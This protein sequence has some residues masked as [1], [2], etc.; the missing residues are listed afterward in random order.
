M[1][2]IQKTINQKHLELQ[3][4]GCQ[5]VPNGSHPLGFFWTAP[6]VEGAGIP[7]HISEPVGHLPHMFTSRP[8]TCNTSQCLSI[9]ALQTKGTCGK[10]PWGS[11]D[12]FLKPLRRLGKVEVI[13]SQLQDLPEV[14]PISLHF[15]CRL[16][17]VRHFD[18]FCKTNELQSLRL[19]ASM[20]RT[21]N[22]MCC[23][24]YVWESLT[25]KRF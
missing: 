17:V 15:L 2:T 14:V 7:S 4:K 11:R 1:Y 12:V 18:T 9:A 3:V 13:S 19:K 20:R 25:I 16:F 5:L 10:R 6:L 21:L 24:R 22:Y 23:L 8:Q